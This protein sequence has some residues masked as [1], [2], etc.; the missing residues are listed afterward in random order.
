MLH[1]DS[2][3]GKWNPGHLEMIA[4]AKWWKRAQKKFGY[5]EVPTLIPLIE[6]Q[7]KTDGHQNKEHWDSNLSH[8]QSTKCTNGVEWEKTH[9]ERR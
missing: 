1:I 9:R 6:D 5:R 3:K 7:W 2:N 8:T 4:N